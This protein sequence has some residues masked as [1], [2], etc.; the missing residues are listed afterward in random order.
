MDQ[1]LDLSDQLIT[2]ELKS[3]STGFFFGHH[4]ILSSILSPLDQED[5]P[6]PVLNTE[7]GALGEV[8]SHRQSG[9]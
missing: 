5:I 2:A 7:A 9:G 4:F 6:S 1:P 8:T 3:F